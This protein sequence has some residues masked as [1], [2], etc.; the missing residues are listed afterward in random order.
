[1]EGKG[2]V[3]DVPA[4]VLDHVGKLIEEDVE[5]DRVEGVCLVPGE[6]IVLLLIECLP[7]GGTFISDFDDGLLVFLGVLV[8]IV[9]R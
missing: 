2:D 5:G 3:A 8:L 9:G 4:S 7:V 1:M 6:A